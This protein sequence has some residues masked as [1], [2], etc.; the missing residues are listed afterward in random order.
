MTANDIKDYIEE[1]ISHFPVQYKNDLG[2]KTGKAL[3]L[4]EAFRISGKLTKEESSQILED[5][6]ESGII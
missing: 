4:L 5:L 2:Y 1:S 6:F 3:G